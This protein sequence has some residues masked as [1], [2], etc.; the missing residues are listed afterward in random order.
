MK[1]ELSAGFVVFRREGPRILYLILQNSSRK[2]WDFP[3]GNIDTG[4]SE[5]D[6]ATRELKEEAGIEKIKIVKGFRGE[7]KYFY[8]FKD[9]LIDK[10]VVIFLGEVEDSDIK[11]SWEHSAYEWLPF[12][13]AKKLLKDKKIEIL[14]RANEFLSSRL[15]KWFK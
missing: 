9:E 8:R 4:E 10:K 15:S 11:L 12:E 6:A 14:E 13:D 3:K 2:F 7:M 1:K 5:E